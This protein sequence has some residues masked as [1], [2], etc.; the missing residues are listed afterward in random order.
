MLLTA[1]SRLPTPTAEALTRLAPERIVVLGGPGAVDDTVLE[2]LAQFTEGPVERLQGNSQE[3][4]DRYGT[5]A[6]VARTLSAGVGAIDTVYI[7]SGENFPDA[8]AGAALAGANQEPVLLTTRDRLPRATQLRLAGF[9]PAH[10]VVL[11]GPGAVST[12]VE[13]QLQLYA[14]VERIGGTDRFVTAA[15]VA[16]LLPD[17]TSAYIAN[18]LAFPDA[19]AG[20]ALAGGKS[21]PILLASPKGLPPVTLTALSR[22]QLD[23]LVVLGGTGAVSPPILASLGRYLDR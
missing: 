21:A 4:S 3:G 14:P 7:A 12:S 9:D 13:Q 19:L 20:A 23:S 10:I 5:S 6:A 16:E 22:H 15:M 17:A 11:G 2:R 8:L 1:G 18:G